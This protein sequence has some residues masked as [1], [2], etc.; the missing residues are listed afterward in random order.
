M[1]PVKRILDSLEEPDASLEALWAKEADVRLAA[2]RREKGPGSNFAS[3]PT[4]GTRAKQ[5]ISM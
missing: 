1:A 3:I 4:K 5:C 2:Y